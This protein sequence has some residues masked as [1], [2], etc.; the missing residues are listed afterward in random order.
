MAIGAIIAEYNPF[1]KGHAYQL[2]ETKKI[3]TDG[4]V[5][6]LS[7]NFVQRG[8]GAVL[9]KEYRVEAALKGGADLV[10]ELPLAFATA[11]A[12]KFALGGVSLADALG[13]IDYLSMGSELGEIEPLWQCAEQLQQLSVSNYMA[14]GITYAAARQQALSATHPHLAELLATP[15]NTL[16]IE[17]C[18]GIQQL[19][20]NI[21]PMTIKRQGAGHHEANGVDGFA[22]GTALRSRWLTE[23][24]Q[25]LKSYI[26]PEAYELYCPLT[27]FNYEMWEE[28]A[29]PLLRRL[30]LEQVALLPDISEGL[31]NRLYQAIGE[32]ESYQ[33]ILALAKSKRYT[34]AR[35][36]RL[37]L[38][39]T[40][41]VTA[42]DLQ[43]LPPYI[44]ILGIGEQGNHILGR[45]KETAKLPFSHSLLQLGEMSD[46]A[47]RFANL[48]ASATDLYHL[49]FPKRKPRGSE[50]RYKLIR[51]R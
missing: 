45:M 32:G 37:L 23:G 5:V 13:C 38:T 10:V 28:L 27:P 44:R 18:R 46:K 42:E 29:M 41:G 20:S 17:Y 12:Q 48:E 51:Q 2:A 16:G 49:C 24:A 1:H 39:A 36:R 3:C 6:I 21:T 14:K 8:E 30:T 34:L 19:G 43:G 47:S 31:E 22:S 11:T 26:T 25:S 33:Q 15:N 40:L 50:Y 35:I 7:G 9:P 4:V